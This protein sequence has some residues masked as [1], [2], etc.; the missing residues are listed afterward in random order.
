VC[1]ASESRGYWCSKFSRK[2]SAVLLLSLTAAKLRM[3]SDD[4]RS[5]RPNPA[6]GPLSSDRFHRLPGRREFIAAGRYTQEAEEAPWRRIE[7]IIPGDRDSLAERNEFE[8]SGPLIQNEKRPISSTFFSPPGNPIM[9]SEGLRSR[10]GRASRG[11]LP[12]SRRLPL[13]LAQPTTS[14]LNSNCSLE[15]N[16]Q[17]HKTSG[18]PQRRTRLRTC[19]R[20]H[21][22]ARYRQPHRPSHRRFDRRDKRSDHSEVSD[23]QADRRATGEPR[24]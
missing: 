14:G 3:S 23:T 12:T 6:S 16:L 9:A 2:I 15:Y 4:R 7:W 17:D 8:P 20:E 13:S 19:A 10:P 24:A 21:Q 5:A 1:G 22:W 11:A 18:V